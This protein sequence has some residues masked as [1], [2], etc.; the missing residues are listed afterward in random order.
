MRE[1]RICYKKAMN[2]VPSVVWVTMNS[3]YLRTP[4]LEIAPKTSHWRFY[5]SFFGAKIVW[6]TCCQVLCLPSF[7]LTV[8]SS[9]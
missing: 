6:S 1:S 8:V 9:M 2:S 4:G 5:G 7:I 3:G